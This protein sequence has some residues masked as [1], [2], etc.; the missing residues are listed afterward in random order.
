MVGAEGGSVVSANNGSLDA[1]DGV[2]HAHDEAGVRIVN[3]AGTGET[4]RCTVLYSVLRY[5]NRN[6]QYDLTNRDCLLANA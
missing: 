2:V 1:D 5:Q 3:G 4:E 6:H